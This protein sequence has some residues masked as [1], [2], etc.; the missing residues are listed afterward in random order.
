MQLL[1]KNIQEH[2]PIDEVF[3]NLRCSHE[4][5]TSEQVQQRLQ[6]FGPNKLEE[7]EVRFIWPIYLPGRF[8]CFLVFVEQ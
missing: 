7:K 1:R 4:G 8:C 2:I 6:I 5:L 3:E